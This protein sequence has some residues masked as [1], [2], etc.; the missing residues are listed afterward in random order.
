MSAQPPTQTKPPS[1]LPLSVAIVCKDNQ[2]TIERTLASV[3]PLA[4]EIIALD[5]G[6]TDNTKHIL[7][8]YNAKIIDTPWLGHI[9]TKQ[10]ALDAATQPWI[11]S[12]DSDESLEPDLAGA[13][14]TTLQSTTNHDQLP[15]AYAINRRIYYRGRFL[16]HAWQP[17]YRVRLVKKNQAAWGGLDP[18]DALIPIP[19][20]RTAK[21]QGTLRHDSFITFTQHFH[22]QWKHAQTNAQSLHKQGKRASYFKLLTSPPAAFLKQLLLK[23]AYRDGYAGWLAAATTSAGALMKHAALLELSRGGPPSPTPSSPPAS[24]PPTSP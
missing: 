1:P 7:K 4:A 6:S 21:L 23:Q 5:S 8:A 3:A 15:D 10:A 24:P 16:K 17:E 19:T 2:S 11:L 9:K 22:S 12:L 20:A 18:H 14:R 13:I